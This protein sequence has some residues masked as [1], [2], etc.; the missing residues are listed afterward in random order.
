MSR[1]GLTVPTLAGQLWPKEAIIPRI[2]LWCRSD[3][4]AKRRYLS[5][6]LPSFGGLTARQLVAEGSA[7]AVPDHLDRIAEGGFA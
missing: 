7:A 6:L 3:N 1:R 4:E 2:R 5:R